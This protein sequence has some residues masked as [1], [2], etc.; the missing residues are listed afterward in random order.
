M[1]TVAAIAAAA[2]D[3]AG[4]AITDALQAVTVT[5]TTPGAYN[6]ATG[7]YAATTAQSTGRGVLD[8]VRPVADIF[9]AHVRGPKDQLWLFE[10]LTALRE[11]DAVA[12]GGTSYTVAA[13]Q[14]IVGAGSLFYAVLQ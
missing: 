5:R 12:I 14:D 11:G 8:S 1:T 2:F 7:A 13:V 3:A 10:G 4:A 9:P 6:P